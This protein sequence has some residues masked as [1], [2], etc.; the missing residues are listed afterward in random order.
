MAKLGNSAERGSMRSRLAW[1]PPF[2]AGGAA[3]TAAEL[4]A[5]L[6]LYSALGFLRALTI[7][8]AVELGAFGLGLWSTQVPRTA[9]GLEWVRR[10]WLIALIAF[11]AAAAFSALPTVTGEVGTSATTRGLGLALL[12]GLPMF[13]IASLLG[14]MGRVQGPGSRGGA[15]VGTAAAFGGA[16]GF[17]ATG[18]VFV[19]LLE[20]LSIL[21]VCVIALSA[22]ALVYG[23]VA[24]AMDVVTLLESRWTAR[25]A[26]NR[27]GRYRADPAL[28][29]R[30]RHA[31]PSAGGGEH[32]PSRGGHRAGRRGLAAGACALSCR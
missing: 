15:T 26:P 19:P 4:A 31:R 29:S 7:V 6:L 32:G 30:S 3:A 8:L 16:A 11:S 1:L 27:G 10:R 2:L 14:A 5:G 22:G 20:P 24:D 28:R 18:F 25:G 23:W 21:L 17:L 9:G 12:G 13:A